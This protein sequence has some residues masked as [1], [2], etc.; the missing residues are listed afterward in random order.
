MVQ[1]R[2]V[3][4]LF[5]RWSRWSLRV[6]NV[7]VGLIGCVCVGRAITLAQMGASPLAWGL[8]GGFGILA[9]AASALTHRRLR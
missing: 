4:G 9:I 6:S 1:N 7:A 5:G 3:G 8:I 2:G